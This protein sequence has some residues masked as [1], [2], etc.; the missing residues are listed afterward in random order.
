[1]VKPNYIGTVEFYEDAVPEIISR[2][3]E[4][5]HYAAEPMTR[6]YPGC[7]AHNEYYFTGK[8]AAEFDVTESSISKIREI[9]EYFQGE[10]SYPHPVTEENLKLTMGE[11]RIVAEAG[12]WLLIVEFEEVATE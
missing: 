4:V 8:V 10:P 7:A 3:V 9:V 11:H 2:F 6:D 1:M 5:D 12:R